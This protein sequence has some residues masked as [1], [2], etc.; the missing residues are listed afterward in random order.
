M[1]SPSIIAKPC[2]SPTPGLTLP[3]LTYVGQDRYL[4]GEKTATESYFSKNRAHSL[5]EGTLQRARLDSR[6][7]IDADD[8][9]DWANWREDTTILE[10][11]KLKLLW[12]RCSDQNMAIA[13]S[14]R[15]Y[16]AWKSNV[17]ARLSDCPLYWK[18]NCLMFLATWTLW[19]PKNSLGKSRSTP[20]PFALLTY[21]NTWRSE[22]WL[23]LQWKRPAT[24]CETSLLC[25][26]EQ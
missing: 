19:W 5:S 26:S 11:S 16:I 17:H 23:R 8:E 13:G 14:N 9:E 20:T 18:H 25:C 15:Q 24:T 7:S 22:S 4:E 6:W 3:T 21:P 10:E 12:S 2:C 1:S